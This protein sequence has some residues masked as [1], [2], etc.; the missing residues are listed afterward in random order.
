M[1]NFAQTLRLVGFV[2]HRGERR[3]SFLA[4]TRTIVRN[5]PPAVAGQ[6]LWHFCARPLLQQCKLTGMDRYS[7]APLARVCVVA[8]E[9]RGLPR[10]TIGRRALGDLLSAMR[11]RAVRD[12]LQNWGVTSFEDAYAIVLTVR[13]V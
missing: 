10:A 6:Q 8:R 5:A 11:D 1:H 3:L 12:E 7:V 13:D 4:L 9:A 2:R